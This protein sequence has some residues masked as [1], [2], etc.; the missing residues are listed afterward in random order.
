MMSQDYKK[1]VFLPRTSF[2]M[3]ADLSKREPGTLTYWQ[4]IQFYGHL[5]EDRKDAEKFIIH[6]GPPYA[7]GHFHMG[8][9]LNRVLKDVI[10]RSQFMQGKNAPFVPGWDCHGLPIEAKVE[11]SYR[12]KKQSKDSVSLLE[13]RQTCRAYAQHWIDIQREEAKRLGILACWDTPYTTMDFAS[14]AQIVR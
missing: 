13:Y 4:D 1:T 5:L 12:L 11:E 8:H 6:D 7:N 2:S 14:E 9:A 10:N 3:K